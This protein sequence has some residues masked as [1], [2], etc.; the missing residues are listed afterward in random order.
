V[1]TS[2]AEPDIQIQFD[3]EVPARDGAVLR[4][5]VARPAGSDRF[6]VII[7]RTPYGKDAA[8]PNPAFDLVHMARA[9]FAVVLQDVRQRFKSDGAGDFRPFVHEAADGQAL[10][11]WAAVQSFS[12]GDVLAVGSSYQGF[13]AWAAATSG[14]D[15]LKGIAAHQ[16]PS[17]FERSLFYR[18]GALELGGV[19]PWFMAL[20]AHD[21]Q[22]RHAA[23]PGKLMPA[24]TRLLQD[25][26]QL[27]VVGFHS[28]PLEDFEPLVRNDVARELLALIAADEGAAESPV[29]RALSAAQQ[30]ERIAV[31]ALISGGYYDYFCQ[32]AIDQ[33]VGMRTRA[34]TPRARERTRLILGP[35]THAA[36]TSLVG[37]RNFGL[38]ASPGS[39]GAGGVRGEVLR[40]C[41]ELLEP[42]EPEE[43]RVKV[44]VMG[45]NVW[46]DELDWPIARTQLTP[47]YLSSGGRANT[48]F[49]DGWLG[50]TP[51][52][53]SPDRFVYDPAT[54]VPTWGGCNL[55]VTELAGP[56]DQRPIEQRQDVL[57][58]TS[59]PLTHDLEV[60]GTAWVELW[61]TSNVLDT[62]F[63][64]RLVDVTLDGTAW[65]VAE[66]ILRGRYRRHG[67]VTGD[68]QPLEPGVP[69]MFRI[70]LT[71][72]SNCF[73][74]GHRLRLDV[75]SSCFPRWDRNLNVWSRRGATLAEAKVAE[76]SVLH[77]DA[78]P[79]RVILPIIPS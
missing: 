39:V 54:P 32:G 56:R 70:E 55:G 25:V 11:A 30:Y 52:L 75:T 68:P 21:L 43:P 12:T 69:T 29:L 61:I 28:L 5:N 58:Y 26:D 22:R 71:P 7:A 46:R 79:S 41:R 38:L 19:V 37:E 36:L 60:T 34:G 50:P 64:V 49:G 24:L 10:V 67:R 63:V 45:A 4:C 65:N 72:T 53:G 33:Y 47:W 18:G 17:T 20:G 57:V 23:D 48:S 76:Q 62:D 13:A 42:D 74:A 66:G 1:N 15:A 40:F 59:D 35:W 8:G 9:G 44:F 51:R 27:G 2:S 16:A 14:S 6:P 78:H 77:D 31:P 73:K 3:V